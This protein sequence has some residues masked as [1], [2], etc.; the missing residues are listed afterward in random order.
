MINLTKLRSYVSIQWDGYKANVNQNP[1]KK[2][3]ERNRFRFF[4]PKEISQKTEMK[5]KKK[6]GK[7]RREKKESVWLEWHLVSAKKK[8]AVKSEW[9]WD[10]TWV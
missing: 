6:K 8:S 7:H 5:G 2:K 9:W 10:F 1:K 4:D 3:D